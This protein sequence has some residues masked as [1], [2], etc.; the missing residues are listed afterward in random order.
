MSITL[1]K[2]NKTIGLNFKCCSPQHLYIGNNINNLKYLRHY[3]WERFTM[4][5]RLLEQR[6]RAKSRQPFAHAKD[7]CKCKEQ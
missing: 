7:T 1:P 2:E 3:V 4:Q 5:L 6:L